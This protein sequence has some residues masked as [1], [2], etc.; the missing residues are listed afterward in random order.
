MSLA[1]RNVSVFTPFR[2]IEQATVLVQGNQIVELGRT[3]EV[4]IPPHAE[5][6][7][8]DG[9]KI[10]P[11]FIDLH[12]HGAVGVDYT[13]ADED[14][15]Q[16]VSSFLLSCGVTGVL[17]TLYPKPKRDYIDDVRRLTDYIRRNPHRNIIRG[18]HLE[19]PYLNKEMHGAINPDYIWT[20]DLHDW[21][22]LRDA[23]SGY[24][25]LM[26]IAPEIP[27][28]MEVIRDAARHGIVSSIG[29]SRAE[30]EDIRVAIDNGAA[31]ITHI[32]NAMAP[33]HHRQP[34]VLTSAFLHG[35]LKVQLIADGLHVHPAVIEMLLKLKGQNGILLISDAMA[36]SGY[37]TGSYSFGDQEVTVDETGA[38][39]ADGTIAG[40][41]AT[42][43]VG[44]KT[45]VEQAGAPCT[46]A[47]RMAS[48]NPSRV[49]GTEHQ[50]GILAVG[51]DADLVV[52]D[53]HFQVVMTVLDGDIVHNRL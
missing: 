32:F 53:E 29:H 48:L 8:L 26:T 37:K 7:D 15:I 23:G 41:V 13:E 27:G 40:S 5:T 9:L 31:Q 36:A 22:D 38:R 18:L 34:G 46:H 12:V 39:L 35:E 52:M 17:A 14:Q 19:G 21:A 42:L 51:K 3:E 20:P 25:R 30:Y 44:V 43:N 6:Y 1:F 33:F 45:M 2:E 16:E 24:I 4:Q 47:F 10:A 49:L 28:A 50:K 11:S